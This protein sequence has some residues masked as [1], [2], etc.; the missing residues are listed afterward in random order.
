[1]FAQIA[2]YFGRVKMS[3]YLG[4]IAYL[5]HREDV[6]A[7]ALY[8]GWRALKRVKPHDKARE[9]RWLQQRLAAHTDTLGS[10][11]ML[12]HALLKSEALNYKDL[13]A[14][15]N[16]LQGLNKNWIP[17]NLAR[18]LFRIILANACTE[19]DFNEIRVQA[20]YWQ[21][22]GS[23]PFAQWVDMYHWSLGVEKVP[24]LMRLK[25]AWLNLRVGNATF[26]NYLPQL[27]NSVVVPSSN[28]HSFA[29]LKQIEASLYAGLHTNAAQLN[30]AWRHY[31]S[32]QAADEWMPRIQVLSCF[33]GQAVYER[34]E[35]SVQDVISLRSGEGDL[36]S[37]AAMQQREN[38]FKLL[39]IKIA[40]MVNRT[41]HHKLMTGIQ[42]YEEFLAIVRVAERLG[43]DEHTR[44][45]A[46]FHMRSPCWNWIAE[47]WNNKKDR[48]L[49]Y[50][51]GNYLAPLAKQFG[52]TEAFDFFT[53]IV[54]NRFS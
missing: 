46:F 50:L 5:L 42:E 30:E 27:K 32:T 49:A 47:M 15:F 41:E 1:V 54:T 9:E 33:N 36:E 53:G 14:H 2:V 23:N 25:I 34:L 29:E 51:A 26:K 10:G 21:L 12:M 6:F 38:A 44:A 7:G 45:Q 13:R 35:R 52:D 16:F 11:A 39:Q 22:V 48:P 19:G 31:L 8:Y 28:S 20:R 3:Y 37:E 43:K 17:A 40:A 24:F 4:R 18:R